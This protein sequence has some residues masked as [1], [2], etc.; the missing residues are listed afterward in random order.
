VS[1]ICNLYLRSPTLI[2]F[3]LKSTPI[4]ATYD[5][6]KLLSQNLVIRFVFPIPLSPMMMTFAMKSYLSDFFF[7]D[8]F[9]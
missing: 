7:Y 1:Q 6:L 2:V 4:V 3:T 9:L 5:Y 8:I